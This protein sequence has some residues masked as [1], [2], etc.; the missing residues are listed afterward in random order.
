MLSAKQKTEKNLSILTERMR[1]ELSKKSQLVNEGVKQIE[2][3]VASVESLKKERDQ[4]TKVAERA[5]RE[6]AV[7]ESIVRKV[8]TEREFEV[9]E[10][11]ER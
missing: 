3:L 6:S 9:A 2:T 7:N 4:A 10:V 8:A 1:L 5:Q 11:S